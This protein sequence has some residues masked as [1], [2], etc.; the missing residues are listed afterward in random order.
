MQNET[1]RNLLQDVDPADSPFLWGIARLEPGAVIED[2]IHELGGQIVVPLT[3]VI[4]TRGRLRLSMFGDYRRD[5][6]ERILTRM[7]TPELILDAT[8]RLIGEKEVHGYQSPMTSHYTDL[9]FLLP[10][11]HAMGEDN[12]LCVPT[13][14]NKR[15]MNFWIAELT[16]MNHTVKR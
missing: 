8:P 16:K 9:L 12:R 4:E 3:P 14:V 7:D 13:S 11:K 10:K 2:H 6:Q 5:D 15:N 1:F